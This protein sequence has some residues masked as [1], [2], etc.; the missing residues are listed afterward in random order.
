M[1]LVVARLH[2][3]HY[4]PLTESLLLVFA[5]L[6]HSSGVESILRFL[7]GMGSIPVLNRVLTRVKKNAHDKYAS[8]VRVEMVPATVDALQYLLTRWMQSQSEIHASYPNKVLYSA[9]IKLLTF[10][11]TPASQAAGGADDASRAA[12]RNLECK[13]YVI[14]APASAKR[15]SRSATAAGAKHEPEYRAVPLST[16]V[17]M[18]LLAEW[19]EYNEKQRALAKKAAKRLA[20][21]SGGA[22]GGAGGDSED[23]DDFDSEDDDDYEDEDD[24]ED[25]EDDFVA[26]MVAKDRANKARGGGGGAGSG[27]SPFADASDY[28]DLGAKGGKKYITLEDMMNSHEEAEEIDAELESEVYPEALTDPLAQVELGP[29]IQ[30]FLAQ[31]RGA[32]NGACMQEAAQYLSPADRKMLDQALAAPPAPVQTTPQKKK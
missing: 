29:A 21:A 4:P 26:Q 27:A 5:R 11:F 6:I 31:F 10:M 23:S 32:S 3:S 19:G 30:G 28:P 13:G 24:D 15:A 17:L 9:L 20:R 16:K 2:S 25:D 22:G 18:L 7:G 12:L 1:S 14:E 8:E